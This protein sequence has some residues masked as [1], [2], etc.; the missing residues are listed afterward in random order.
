MD[1][2]SVVVP[3]YENDDPEELAK[4]L[5]S[6]LGQTVPPDEV[7]IVGDGPLT[8]ELET[9][10]SRIEEDHAGRV[11]L[12]QLSEN[13]GKGK[14]RQEGVKQTTNQ[15]VAMMDA[16]DICRRDRFELQLNYL[17]KNPETDVVGS[18]FTEF[19]PDTGER[20]AVRKVPEQHEEIASTAR[21]R[22]PINQATVMFRKD[23]VMEV[24]NYEDVRR[25][26]DYRLWVR[27][28]V[29]GAI[30]GNI[31]ESLVH[32]R[33]GENMHER[34]GGAAYAMSEVRMQYDFYCWGFIPLWLAVFN[35]A[36]R[37]IVRT[38]PNKLR[39]AVYEHLLRADPEEEPERNHT[40]ESQS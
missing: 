37:V 38:L 18:Y 24:G 27:L 12:F 29:N 28:L 5:E 9:T 7:I 2:L 35:A 14:A 1:G 13:R 10:I 39:G 6:V 26:E 22:S 3:T 33:A 23:S 17:K 25:L 11:E 15:V 40:N 16:D 32:V 34:R 31:P 8:A 20:Y 36:T 30:F 19:D 4:A 21:Y